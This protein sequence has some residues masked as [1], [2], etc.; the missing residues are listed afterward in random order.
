MQTIEPD[1]N[2]VIIQAKWRWSQ[3]VRWRCTAIASMDQYQFEGSLYT[4]LNRCIRH[5]WHLGRCRG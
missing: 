1:E 5:R 4:I 3:L 2:N